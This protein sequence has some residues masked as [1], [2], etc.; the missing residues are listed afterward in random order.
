MPMFYVMF[1][2]FFYLLTCD[3]ICTFIPILLH[4]LKVPWFGFTRHNF[5]QYVSTYH[6]CIGPWM[7]CVCRMFRPQY[8]R[9]VGMVHVWW[10]LF[11]YFYIQGTCRMILKV[12]RYFFRHFLTEKKGLFIRTKARA[13]FMF[14]NFC[15]LCVVVLFS[16]IVWIV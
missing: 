16:G 15:N 8:M 2:I 7:F 1:L 11:L 10:S 3:A 13:T 12:N 6:Y 9:I 14:T 4:H 5:F